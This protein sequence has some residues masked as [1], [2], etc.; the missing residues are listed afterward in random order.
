M[1]ENKM[2]YCWTILPLGQCQLCDIYGNRGLYDHEFGS[3][4]HDTNK[5]HLDI[6]EKDECKRRVTTIYGKI[7]C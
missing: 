1:E 3:H 4:L 5:M 2:K 6:V 7:F